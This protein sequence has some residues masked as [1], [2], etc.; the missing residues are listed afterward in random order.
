MDEREKQ[1]SVP[2]F[3]HEGQ[4]ARMERITKR[5]SITIIAV[6]AVAL[7]MFIINN[8]IWLNYIQTI[9]PHEVQNVGV[10]EQSDQGDYP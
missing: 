6:L 9:Q 7:I 4:M 3:I 1:A 10:H 8:M 2:Y 5:L